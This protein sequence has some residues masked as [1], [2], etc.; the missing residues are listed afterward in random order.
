MIELKEKVA[1]VTGG[2]SGIGA[3][4]A[5]HLIDRGVKVALWDKVFTDNAPGSGERFECDVTSE[6]AVISALDRTKTTLGVPHYLVNCAGILSAERIVGREGSASLEVF[7][8]TLN[9]NLA[10][11]FN[12]M[13]L[14]ANEM[15][16]QTPHSDDGERGVIVNLASVAA[17][18]GQIGQV[19]YAASK[20][21]IVSMT[22]PA[23]RE[24]ARLGIRVNCIAPGIVDTPMMAEVPDD[25][26]EKLESTIPFPKRYVRPAEIGLLVTQI[27]ENPIIN[28][29]VIRMDGAMRLPPK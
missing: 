6:K 15:A 13:R 14:V 1:V 18:E 23:A 9:V 5:T 26:R 10:G 11:S 17:Y 27:F 8:K 28:G 7:Q 29:E 3:A 2:G 21:G 24:L 16:K 22:L 19:A 12:T 4:V 20:G 25:Y